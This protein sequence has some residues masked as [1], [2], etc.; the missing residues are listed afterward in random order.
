M[1]SVSITNNVSIQVNVTTLVVSPPPDRKPRGKWAWDI[2]RT[3]ALE[4]LAAGVVHILIDHG[5]TIL[6]YVFSLLVR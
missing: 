6:E 4:I 5:P 1:D 2:T 3:V